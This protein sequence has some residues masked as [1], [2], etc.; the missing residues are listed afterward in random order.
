MDCREPSI[1]ISHPHQNVI[2]SISDFKNQLVS[3]EHVSTCI[4]RIVYLLLQEHLCIPIHRQ[5]QRAESED[6]LGQYPYVPL[7][8][9]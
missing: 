6:L 5:E 1:N 4:K 8:D 9:G 3:T 7:Q 2:C